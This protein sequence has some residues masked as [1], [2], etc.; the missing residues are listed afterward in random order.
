MTTWTVALCGLAAVFA[1][2]TLLWLISLRLRDLTI[3][4]TWWGPGF[5]VLAWLYALLPGAAGWRPAVVAILVT[6]WGMRLATHLHRRHRGAGEDP[7]YRAIRAGFGHAFWW[8]SLFAVFWLQGALMW[9]IAMPLLAAARR[10]APSQPGVADAAGL[11]LFLAGFAFEAVGDWQLTRFKAQ[12]SS[13]GRVLDTGLWRYTRHPNYFGDA[14]LWWGIYLLA[15]AADWAWLTI[16]SPALMTFLL[17]RVSGVTLLERGLAASKPGYADYVARTP[18][19]FPWF[20][21]RP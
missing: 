12:P 16:A 20:P 9:F 10:P 14:L 1:A 11:L 3:A 19:F 7:R 6:G 18:A 4:D 21:R 17:L 2:Q 13:R 15:V 8:K 5:A